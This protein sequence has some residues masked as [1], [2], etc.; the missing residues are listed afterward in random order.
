MTLE[1]SRLWIVSYNSLL[2]ASRICPFVSET[3]I[4]IRVSKRR[5]CF[6]SSLEQLGEYDC[7]PQPGRYPSCRYDFQ[8]SHSVFVED[9]TSW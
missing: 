1:R 3:G 6:K 7:V 5:I 2:S 8:D 4:E 9:E